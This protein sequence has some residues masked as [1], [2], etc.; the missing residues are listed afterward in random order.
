MTLVRQ[1]KSIQRINT[2]SG[3]QPRSRT[4]EPFA[5]YF[6]EF[7]KTP[8]LRL[9]DVTQETGFGMASVPEYGIVI[10]LVA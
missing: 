5:E 1:E 8:L 4:H 2:R 6:Q 3:T 10:Y 7:I 9:K